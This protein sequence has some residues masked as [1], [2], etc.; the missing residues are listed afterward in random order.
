MDVPTA[1]ETIDRS[2][3]RF[4]AALERFKD[5]ERSLE[6]SGILASL[7][8]EMGIAST[9]ASDALAYVSA[10]DW[11]TVDDVMLMYGTALNL[12]ARLKRDAA[13]GL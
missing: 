7:V 9:I 12:N 2:S 5:E 8:D 13:K 4:Y 10:K 11:S 1:Y 3:R 6:R